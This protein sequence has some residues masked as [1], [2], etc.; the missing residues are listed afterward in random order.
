MSEERLFEWG[1]AR[2]LEL[3]PENRPALTRS[4]RRSRGLRVCGAVVGVLLPTLVGLVW[5]GELVVLGFHSDGSAAPYAGPVE[6]YIGSLLGALAAEVSLARPRDPGRRAASLTP[7]ELGDY[8]PRRL[9]LAQRALG[10]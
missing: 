9:L 2:G 4:L 5:H 7:R 10:V 3:T 6:A 1:R 8:L